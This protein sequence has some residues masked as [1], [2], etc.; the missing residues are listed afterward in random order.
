MLE[1]ALKHHCTLDTGK[2]PCIMG[3]EKVRR[4]G[5]DLKERLLFV[6]QEICTFV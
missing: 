2:Q 3:K 4:L 6:I 5:I 1:K